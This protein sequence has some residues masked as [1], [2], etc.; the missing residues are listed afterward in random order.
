MIAET[1]CSAHGSHAGLYNLTPVEPKISKPDVRMPNRFDRP[2][3]Y[4]QAGPPD[5]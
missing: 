5:G 1:R 2:S 3:L 4:D